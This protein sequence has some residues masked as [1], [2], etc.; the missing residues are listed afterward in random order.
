MIANDRTFYRFLMTIDK[1]THTLIVSE[2]NVWD[3]QLYSQKWNAGGVKS[4]HNY[5]IP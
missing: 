4:K 2:V 3:F 5:T 1:S